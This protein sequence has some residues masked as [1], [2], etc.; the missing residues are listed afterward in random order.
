ML[1]TTPTRDWALLANHNGN[2]AL[3]VGSFYGSSSA[4]ID[5]LLAEGVVRD[6]I[7]AGAANGRTALMLAVSGGNVENVKSLLAH[8]ASTTLESSGNTAYDISRT[9]G[10]QEIRKLLRDHDLGDHDEF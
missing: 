2:T 9:M 4:F 5:V 3:E 8:G 7:D 10:H 1:A 6:T